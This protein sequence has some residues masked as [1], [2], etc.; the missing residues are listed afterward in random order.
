M[1]VEPVEAFFIASQVSDWVHG[2]CFEMKTF[3]ITFAFYIS[4]NS[5]ELSV[6]THRQAP[7]PPPPQTRFLLPTAVRVNLR[8]QNLEIVNDMRLTF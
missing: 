4:V 2:S 8:G 3:A 7:P 5:I 1:L 6:I